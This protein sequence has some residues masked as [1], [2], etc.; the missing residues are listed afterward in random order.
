MESL[1]KPH[2]EAALSRMAG[3]AVV[4]LPQDTGALNFTGLKKTTGPGPLG[5]EPG[6]KGRGPWLHSMLAYRPDGVPPGVLDARC[7][8]RQEAASRQDRRGRNAKSIDEKESARWLDALHLAA[9]AARRIPATRLVNITDREGDLYEL[10]DCIGEAP[11][12]LHN[13]IRAQHDRNLEGHNKP[14]AF[15]AGQACG[16]TDTI[17]VP[18]RRGQKAR[19]AT[20]QIRWSP[21]TIEAPKV[22]AK[23]NRPPLSLWAVWLCEPDPPA[24]VEPLQ[25]MLLTDMPIANAQEAWEKVRWYR[26][27]WGIEEWHRVIK[28]GCRA[29]A[30][31]FKSAEHLKRVLAFDLIV[32]WRILA[33][34]KLGHT[35]PQLPATVICTAEELEVLWAA[36][37]KGQPPPEPTIQQANRMVAMPGGYA[38]RKGDKQPGA[39]SLGT[40]LRRLMDLT[41]GWSLRNRHPPN[42]ENQL[43]V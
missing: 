16:A 40:G 26:C 6:A 8:A 27:R 18:R 4:L 37:K 33:C 36:Q 12:N 31:E 10:H 35:P 15:M 13:L 20:V 7:R 43:C 9:E 30:R 28:S 24:G 19:K 23:K 2:K 22:G 42:Q 29:E 11:A 38:G 34:V 39:E 17:E 21:I 3:E 1:L 41:W 25:W 14:W 5:D 32:A